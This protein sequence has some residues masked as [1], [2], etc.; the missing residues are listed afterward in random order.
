MQDGKQ[1]NVCLETGTREEGMTQGSEE[2][3]QGDGHVG[4]VALVPASGQDTSTCVKQH[5]APWERAQFTARGC[6]SGER[7]V[8]KQDKPSAVLAVP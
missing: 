1:S 2:R 3:L 8:S 7:S 6:A 4:S 5:T